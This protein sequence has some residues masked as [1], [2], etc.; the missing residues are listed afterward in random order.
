MHSFLGNFYLEI[1]YSSFM[2]VVLIT[3]QKQWKLI[4]CN[5]NGAWPSKPGYRRGAWAQPAT[6]ATQG[7]TECYAEG[8]KEEVL[9]LSHIAFPPDISS[10]ESFF[11]RQFHIGNA[12]AAILRMPEGPGR[13]GSWVPIVTGPLVT[14]VKRR[15]EEFTE[16]IKKLAVQIGLDIAAMV[17]QTGAFSVPAAAYAL[18]N[19]DYLGC[20]LN[21]LGAIPLFGTLADAAK[22][23]KVSGR[24]SFLTKEITFLKRWLE[25]STEA[26]RRVRQMTNP[27]KVEIQG[28]TRATSVSKT[29]TKTANALKNA[30]WL[31][32]I[33]SAERLGLLPEEIQVLRKLAQDG[34]YFVI[35]SCNP[36]RVTW[37][38]A[39]ARGGWGM[40]GKPVWLK[41]KSLKAGKFK[42]L[43]GFGK[44][45]STYAQT[46]KSMEEMTELPKGFKLPWLSGGGLQNAKVYRLNKNFNVPKV[47]D[48][49]MMLEH[50]FVDV[51]DSFIIVDR[52][53]RPYVPD[54]DIVSIQRRVSSGAFGPPGHNIGPA[55]PVSEFR[56]ADDAQFSAHWNEVFAK[57]GYPP[58]YKPFGWHGGRGGTAAFTGPVPAGFRPGMDTRGLGWN[59]ETPTEDLI[60][61]VKGVENL[62]DDVGYVTG[63][64]QLQLF[65]QA[66]PMGEWRFAVGR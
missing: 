64:D 60:V 4:A 55:K 48:S 49:A 62:G 7:L 35:R 43:V 50:Y 14:E 9:R 45:D 41:I 47:D 39:A 31:K 11:K 12:W 58:G 53:G 63:W 24:L 54:L 65:H 66:N 18:R 17:D 30:G 37:L 36:E 1:K 40:L 15:L 28:T 22:V 23:A 56:T 34:Y 52:F 6:Y 44:N 59:P 2:A 20:T 27:L 42:G 51:G 5:P 32:K 16:E 19:G 61:A 38:R 10:D 3:D 8:T 21:L 46:V 13:R 33:S 29:V 25:M 26:T 57:V